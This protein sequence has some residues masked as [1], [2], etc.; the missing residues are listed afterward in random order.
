MKSRR[1]FSD[2]KHRNGNTQPVLENRTKRC[3]PDWPRC[4]IAPQAI[5]VSPTSDVRSNPRGDTSYRPF[6][7]SYAPCRSNWRRPRV[8]MRTNPASMITAPHTTGC[9]N[10]NRTNTTHRTVRTNQYRRRKSGRI[11]SLPMIIVSARRSL[12]MSD[13]STPDGFT[14]LRLSACTSAQLPVRGASLSTD[15]PRCACRL[16]R[17]H[18]I[19]ADKAHQSRARTPSIAT[20]KT[21]ELVSTNKWSAVSIRVAPNRFSHQARPTLRRSREPASTR[22][23][24]CRY[25]E[26]GRH[27]TRASPRYGS[28]QGGHADRELYGGFRSSVPRQD[29]HG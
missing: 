8:S 10:D 7:T 26:T 24:E 3:S 21:I 22:T 15:G 27:Q 20:P 1:W 2:A 28:P 9:A 25:L 23:Y 18:L 11:G 5:S 4:S 16:V 12:G 17:Q 19:A 6:N 29:G 13:M 14:E